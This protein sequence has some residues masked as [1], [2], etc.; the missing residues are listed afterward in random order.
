[1]PFDVVH[2]RDFQTRFGLARPSR[3]TLRRWRNDHGFP[4]PLAIPKGYYKAEQVAGWLATR[5]AG[6]AEPQ[7]PPPMPEL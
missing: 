5:Q 4:Q 1:M 6:P 7:V 3:A 2:P